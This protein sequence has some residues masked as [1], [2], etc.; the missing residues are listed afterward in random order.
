ML[1]HSERF[2][3]VAGRIFCLSSLFFSGIALADVHPSV[4][5]GEDNRKDIH[6]VS[7]SLE[8]ALADSTVAL[9]KAADLEN[10]KIRRKTIIRGRKFG[11]E[12]A[13]C[14]D[15]PFF[16]QPSAAFCSGSLVA[17]DVVMTAGHCIVDAQECLNTRF[18]F[19]YNIK[20]EGHY[21]T[22]VP[23][24]EVYS[25]GKII[26]REQNGN[27]A[28]YALIRLNRRVPNHAVLEVNRAMDPPN[29]TPLVVI[30]HP[31]GLPTKVSAGAEVRDASPHGYFTANLD[32]YGG[33]SG[34]AVF[35]A[36]TG[37][38]EGILVRGERD[39]VRRESG[40][41]VSNR[42]LNDGCRGEDVTK[43]TA[44]AHHLP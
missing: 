17:R 10:R 18:V 35:N 29:G 30:G 32:T 13:L 21:P 34:S 24:G 41:A 38:V 14:S 33:N 27:G 25:C 9:M 19:G 20:Q 3:C 15:E 11:E 6:E 39:F 36:V 40:C 5:Y 23:T 26:A 37:L 28:D 7:S 1:I 31:S 44:L 2:S 16:D 22:E 4:I 42:C 12:F 43:M 8:L